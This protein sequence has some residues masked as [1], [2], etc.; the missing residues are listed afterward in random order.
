MHPTEH[1]D[2]AGVV[3][4]TPRPVVG[5]T[6]AREPIHHGASWHQT[7]DFVPASYV[8]AI[9]RAGGR[10]VLLPVDPVDTERP[11][12][13][14]RGLDGLILT[15]GVDLAPESYGAQRH[16][17]T[18]GDTPDRDAFEAALA[19]AAQA[20]DLPLLAICRGMQIV[21][22]AGGG[23]LDQHLPETLGT[24]EH[25]RVPG[26]LDERNAHDVELLPGSLAARAVG[27]DVATVR[28]HHHQAVDRLPEHWQITGSAA[29]DGL[30]EAIERTDRTFCLAVQWHPEGD[31]RSA[32]IAALVQAAHE[33]AVS[34]GSTPTAEDAETTDVPANDHRS[35]A[36][37]STE[38]TR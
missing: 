8:A 20:D 34:R 14:L 6:C 31:P 22:A 18:T 35:A 26:T 25:R 36:P 1:R 24:V 3:I 37:D 28:S 9:Q 4:T 17:E 15:G 30:T 19:L 5:V 29:G 11:R 10:A 27:A 16:P 12:D 23:T 33:H 38:E 32:V 2:A 7:A 21:A 13:A